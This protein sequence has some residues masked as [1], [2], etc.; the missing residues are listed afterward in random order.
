MALEDV[1]IC[2]INSLYFKGALGVIL[3]GI[4]GSR[5]RK[6]I[7]IQKLSVDYLYSFQ[8]TQ[9]IKWTSINNKKFDKRDFAIILTKV[10]QYLN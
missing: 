2:K 10:I 3:G 6:R 7:D 1:S 5:I 4:I 9:I 8:I